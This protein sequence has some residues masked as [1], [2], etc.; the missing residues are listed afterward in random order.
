MSTAK[1][2]LGIVPGL[3]A[4]SLVAYNMPNFKMKLK[5]K[6]GMKK[7][8]RNIIKRG[9]GTMIGI[10]MIKPTAEMINAMD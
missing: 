4:T 5:K 2:I 7:P 10:G 3:Q 9:V 6:M 1:T 8:V